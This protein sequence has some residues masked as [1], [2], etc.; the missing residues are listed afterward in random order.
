MSTL[1]SFCL[2][3]NSEGKE[4]CGSLR[5]KEW[6]SPGISRAVDTSGKIECL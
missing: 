6:V 4:G 2:D 3:G 5:K 1:C